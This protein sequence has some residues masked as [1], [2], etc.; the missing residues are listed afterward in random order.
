LLAASTVG[1]S[2]AF[3]TITGTA[4][5]A[6]VW[7]HAFSTDP[8]DP[9]ADEIVSPGDTL[10]LPAGY[11]S[12]DWEV[13]AASGGESSGTGGD[14]GTLLTGT[15]TLP[16]SAATFTLYPGTMGGD[17]DDAGTT[18]GAGGTN[19]HGDDGTAGVDDGSGVYGGGG[20]AAS[21]VVQGG[22]TFL[23]APGGNGGEGTGGGGQGG[24]PQVL[25]TGVTA[26]VG[27]YGDGVISGEAIPCT[28]A[29]QV[30]WVMG[31]DHSL[32]YQMD[33][34]GYLGDGESVTG[35]QYR[36]DGGSW[37]T[38]A[39]HNEGDYEYSGTIPGL[40][41]AQQYSVEFRFLTTNTTGLASAAVTAAP[42]LPAPT[43]VTAV[44]GESSI[45]VSWQ[46][47]A[48]NTSPISSYTAWAEPTGDQ[49]M[50]N[51]PPGCTT[52]DGST[53]TCTIV[54]PAG[55]PYDVV[56]FASD[57]QMGV[58][59]DP[60][61]TGTVPAP[62]APVTVPTGS[63]PLA[64][65]SGAPSGLAQG[66]TVTL[67]GSG[68]A[69]NSTVSVYIYSTPTLLGTAL[70]NGSGAFSQAFTI[71][72]SLAPGAHH[73]VSAGLDPSGNPRYLTSAVTVAQ[74]SGTLA[75]TGFETLPVLGGGILAVALG[76]GLIVVGRRRRTA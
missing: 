48:G 20:G 23:R 70:T 47:P 26:G 73:L 74:A 49:Q 17:G 69:P 14:T 65:P 13:L 8:N 29:P 45:T 9:N 62:S 55:A 21:T 41:T 56:V 39:S 31:G 7:P 35:T 57:A 64:T 76:A 36:L 32:D 11:C 12:V 40:T 52:P 6:G 75:W 46:P 72:A 10:S 60:V 66:S 43:D 27:D 22:L 19:G 51:E 25:Q 54:V 18:G 71:P 28:G 61:R 24:G 50:G 34:T 15:T 44:T 59:S 33:R 67:T 3:L 30:N 37:T 2:A 53:L 5:A 4:S 63:G 16:G 58:Q 1:L 38:I 42:A 68:Y